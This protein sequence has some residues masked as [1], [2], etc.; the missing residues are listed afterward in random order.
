MPYANVADSTGTVHSIY[1]IDTGPVPESDD[2]HTVFLYHGAMFNGNSF[3]RILPL[4]ASQNLRFVAPF[5]RDY[6]ESGKYTDEGV[7]DLRAGKNIFLENLGAEVANFLTWFLDKNEI[8]KLSEDRKRGGL[9][10]LSW[11]MGN[12][13]TFA[14]FGQP[15][16]VSSDIYRKVEPYIRN[17]VIY[18]SPHVSYGFSL[19]QEGYSPFED[20][21]LKTPEEVGRHFFLWLTTYYKHAPDYYKSTKLD[22]F[23]M[24][25]NG[26]N[27]SLEDMTPEERATIVQ[28]DS[29][30]RSDIGFAPYSQVQGILSD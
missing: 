17:F 6:G 24:R 13:A 26:K 3:K 15:K 4:A 20:P 18:D 7:A 11:S 5:R 27:S 16:A 8:P 10:L 22:Y 23:D 21:E 12:A 29:A 2:Y 30:G 19:P 28:P 9:S 1:F 14:F 25:R